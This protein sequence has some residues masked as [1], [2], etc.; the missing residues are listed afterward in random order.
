MKPVI[1][2]QRQ[3]R[4]PEVRI[5]LLDSVGVDR[6]LTPP[7]LVFELSGFDEFVAAGG[8]PPTQPMDLGGA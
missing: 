2:G 5:E 8:W 3:P 7:P 4:P 6:R 1:D